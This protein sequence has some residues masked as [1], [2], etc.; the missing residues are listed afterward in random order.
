MTDPRTSEERTFNKV[1]ALS[2]PRVGN[3]SDGLIASNDHDCIYLKD[4]RYDHTMHLDRVE[5]EALRD[6]LNKVLPPL[7]AEAMRKAAEDMYRDLV[8]GEIEG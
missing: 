4:H 2:V 7:P 3:D 5:A 6:W 8:G 1:A